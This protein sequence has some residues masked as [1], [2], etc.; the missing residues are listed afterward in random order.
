MMEM[1]PHMSLLQKRERA[2]SPLEGEEAKTWA[3]VSKPLVFADEGLLAE[4][5][6]SPAKSK[7]L[8]RKPRISLPPPQGGRKGEI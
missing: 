1:I 4:N 5:N 8:L 2:S 6:P 3:C 7:D